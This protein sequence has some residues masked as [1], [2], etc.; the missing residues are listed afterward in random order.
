MRE[1]EPL[2]DQPR[3]LEPFEGDDLLQAHH[4]GGLGGQGGAEGHQALFPRAEAVPDVEG[5]DA[6]GHGLSPNLP[7]RRPPER[8]AA[9]YRQKTPGIT[10]VPTKTLYARVA[11]KNPTS[12]PRSNISHRRGAW[13][14]AKR[15]PP[16]RG[17]TGAALENA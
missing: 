6:E 1:P 13:V 4:V 7:N 3:L 11:G 17:L 9:R 12:P 5:G 10:V 2:G 15:N 14:N 16:S 8:P